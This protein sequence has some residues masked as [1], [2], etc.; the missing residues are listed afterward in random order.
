M[1]VTVRQK[2]KGKGKPWW[3]FISHNGKRTSRMVGDKSAAQT[4]ASEIRAKLQLGEFGFEQEERHE[5]TFKEY[6][7]SWI[8]KI[9]PAECKG[10]TLKGYRDLLNNHVLPVFGNLK[11][12]QI[13]RGKV[14]E[15][16]AEKSNSGYAKSTVTHMKN[17]I[18]NVFNKAVDDEVIATNPALNLGKKMMKAKNPKEDI[19]PLTPEELRLLLNTVKNDKHLRK[20]YPLFLL[21]AR[22]GLRIGEALALQ[23][24]D[25]DFSGRFIHIQRGLSRQ[26]IETPKNGKT[27][28]VDMSLQLAETLKAHMFGGPPEFLF[29]NEKG[30]FIDLVNW[31]ARVFNK[32][33]KKAGLRKIRIHDLRHTYAT[34]R[35][36]KGDSILDVSNQLGHYSVKLT[37]DTYSHW[38]PGKKKA[39][40]DELDDPEYRQYSKVTT[41]AR[42]IE[43]R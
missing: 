42:T 31:R 38:L 8:E 15:F 27:R 4:V 29:T 5:P 6:A 13:T 18:S 28:R 10:S 9:A 23:P 2:I 22:T 41:L 40:V 32:A 25:V 11:L 21:L 35:I 33:L 16:L 37:L 30:G 20:D 12:T 17:V 7:D 43:L 14:K 24:G 1:G 39:E 3:V 19:N 36:A 26:Q 34:L